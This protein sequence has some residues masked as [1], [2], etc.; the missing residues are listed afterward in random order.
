MWAAINISGR[1]GGHGSYMCTLIRPIMESLQQPL[2]G[3]I[4]NSPQYGWKEA[5]VMSG[6]SIKI[7]PAWHGRSQI[8]HTCRQQRHPPRLHRNDTRPSHT[9]HGGMRCKVRLIIRVGIGGRVID[10]CPPACSTAS[11]QTAPGW[12]SSH[13]LP[14]VHSASFGS[15][16]N[17]R[18][19][20]QQRRRAQDVRVTS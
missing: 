12:A 7:N 2:Y 9:D 10:R 1:P 15:N 19:A 8:G 20:G 16:T 5:H 4:D 6:T 11:C 18:T 13:G 3:P 14:A 17:F